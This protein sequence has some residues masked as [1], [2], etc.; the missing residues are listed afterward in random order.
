M[1]LGASEAVN[2]HRA[3][4]DRCM[5]GAVAKNSSES[6]TIAMKG[7]KA[8]LAS[9]IATALGEYFV[10]DA[11][12]IESKLLHDAKI[13]LEDLELRPIHFSLPN[14][15]YFVTLTGSVKKVVL[16]W[17]WGKSHTLFGGGS[18][19]WVQDAALEIC[20][21]AICAKII[22]ETP[23][24]NKASSATSNNVQVQQAT[25]M[26]NIQEE[27]KKK[28]LQDL[29]Q[30]Y[31]DDQVERVLDSLKI[32]LVDFQ[33]VLELPNH[34]DEI[35]YRAELLQIESLGRMNRDEK[36]FVLTERL[37][38]QGLASDIIL[39]HQ[40]G[41]GETHSQT[42]T[43]AL[44]EPFG[45]SAEGTRTGTKRFSSLLTGCRFVGKSSTDL[46]VHAGSLQL[47][48]LT[49][50]GVVVMAPPDDAVHVNKMDSSI[51][52][53]QMQTKENDSG[54]PSYF[55]LNFVSI[56][57]VHDSATLNTPGVVIKYRADG[58]EM[59]FEV[60]KFQIDDSEALAFQASGIRAYMANPTTVKIDSIDKVYVKNSFELTR[61]ITSIS[62]VREGTTVSVDIDMIEGTL[63]EKDQSVE[64]ES[65]NSS[66]TDS[67]NAIA[68]KAPFPGSMSFKTIRLQNASDGSTMMLQ[69]LN[70]FVNP[71]GQST[72]L[73][74]ELGQFQNHLLQMTGAKFSGAFPLDKSEQID[75]F[76][77]SAGT[78]K[79][80]GGRPAEEWLTT[81]TKPTNRSAKN[82]K[83]VEKHF[84]S[85]K[86]EATNKERV[87]HSDSSKK[88]A[89]PW[90][91][92]FAKVDPLKL[93]LSFESA[94]VSVKDTKIT[95]LP[96]KGKAETTSEDLIVHYAHVCMGR[97]SDFIQNSEILGLNVVDSGAST[98][99]E[100]FGMFFY[101]IGPLMGPTLG[102]L[103][104]IMVLTGIDA[105]KGGIAA[106]KRSRHVDEGMAMQPLDVIRGAIYSIHEAAASG[107][108]A[109]GCETSIVVY[110]IDAAIGTMEATAKY[111]NHNKTRLGAAGAGG[112]GMIA[113]AMLGG[114]VGAIFG[115]I[116]TEVVARKTLDL[117]DKK[118]T[119]WVE[120]PVAKSAP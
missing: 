93:V 15:I 51:P 100:Y 119:K 16:T 64:T 59:S 40:Q 75:D 21:I 81:F 72:Q 79:V 101:H 95:T 105:I 70:V 66:D 84:V 65:S 25:A 90:K 45:Y 10:V 24:E 96:Y 80:T 104:G 23:S 47:G 92:P 113:G 1:T 102:P 69:G 57:V 97:V 87:K 120:K 115:G 44:L 73:A 89:T 86:E 116:I 49:K 107:A 46:V 2:D 38:I 32:G 7:L 36:S 6:T 31:V 117:A 91:L 62:I 111:V 103:T 9:A 83:E 26:E 55:E 118:Y 56:S 20:G 68:F 5:I 42:T 17:A 58:T 99:S 78:S 54:E 77:F 52:K 19:D 41:A 61:P 14:T 37:I 76:E 27:G 11:S 82:K 4:R 33:F 18:S 106:G 12:N 30:A 63:L 110:P 39:G 112:G 88:A 50:L 3:I 67:S 60:N 85:R 35:Q 98:V 34:S 43:L 114:P 13:K 53:D 22:E 108:G 109:R 29:L 74:I 71:K 28:G 48:V 94:G 8:V